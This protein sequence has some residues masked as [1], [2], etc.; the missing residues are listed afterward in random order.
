M[1]F[2]NSKEEVIDIELTQYGKL[3]LSRGLL[4]PAFYSFHDDDILYD[5]DYANVSENTNLAEVRIQDETPVLKPLYSFASGKPYLNHDIEQDKFRIQKANLSI[6]KPHLSNIGLSNSSISNLYLPAWEI[7][8]LSSFFTSSSTTYTNMN[9][10][11]ASIPQF[12]LSIDTVFYK[13]NQAQIDEIPKL[14]N[15]AVLEKVTYD[16]N[17]MYINVN[18]PLVLKIIENNV[19]FDYDA[20]DVEIYKVTLDEDNNEVYSQMKFMKNTDNYNE[21]TD[22]YVQAKNLISNEENIDSSYADFYF[23]TL[24]DKEISNLNVCKFILKTSQDQDSI[25]DDIT[26]CDELRTGFSTEDL[27]NL[28]DISTGKT[29]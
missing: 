15:L 8:N 17:N 7:Q 26:V 4:K 27:Y 20:F 3:L 13:T 2:F 14:Q 29:C 10:V 23:E 11:S 19:D 25:F 5:S 18:K 28:P 16:T 22:L 6:K 1:A 24:V 9:N 12:E 21:E